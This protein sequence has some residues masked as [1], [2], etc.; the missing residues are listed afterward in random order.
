MAVATKE[1]RGRESSGEKRKKKEK[2][3]KKR[4]KSR[5]S[6]KS[7][8]GSRGSKGSKG[9]GSSKGSGKGRRGP[10]PSIPAA[11]CLLSALVAGSAS[12]ADAHAFRKDMPIHDD[13]YSSSAFPALASVKFSSTAPMRDMLQG[14]RDQTRWALS[15]TASVIATSRLALV[16]SRLREGKPR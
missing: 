8:K 10:K 2:K 12:Q 13:M 1:M 16:R 9:S 5:S 14:A 7:S 15:W 3:D 11:V 6:S 4:K